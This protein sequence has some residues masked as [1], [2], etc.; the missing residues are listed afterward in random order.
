MQTEIL[1]HSVIGFLAQILM[2][3][4]TK[5]RY[6]VSRKSFTEKVRKFLYF[7]GRV[8]SSRFETVFNKKSADLFSYV[9][10]I[11]ICSITT[12]TFCHFTEAISQN[13]QN[14]ENFAY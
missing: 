1:G 7:S 2:S 3:Q 14:R 8:Q 10:I 12:R 13:K 5:K 9:I 4:G 11:Q 6:Y